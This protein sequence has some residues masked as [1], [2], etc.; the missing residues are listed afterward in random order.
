MQLT[1]AQIQDELAFWLN[2]DREHNLFLHLGLEEPRLKAM[3]RELFDQYDYFFRSR[4]GDN[5]QRMLRFVTPQS[6]AFKNRVLALQNQGRWVGWLFPSFVQ[7]I[8]DEIDVMLARIRPG[9]IS[10]R[11]ELCFG[12]RMNAD[13]IAFASHLLDPLAGATDPAKKLAAGP[14]YDSLTAK[15]RCMTDT[16]DSLLAIS[17]QAGGEVDKFFTGFDLRKF[18]SVIHPAL[19][20]HVVR[21]GQR[22]L[23]TIDRLPAQAA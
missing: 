17:R 9:G 23:K 14:L 10:S 2:Q 5:L 1:P 18:P 15:N 16:Y 19:A 11:D 6:Q 12:N 22:F 4:F 8:R 20:A 3:A 7:H 21:E 13:H